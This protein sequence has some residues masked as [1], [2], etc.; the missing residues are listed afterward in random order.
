MAAGSV[1]SLAFVVKEV[2]MTL[3]P[4]TA[5]MGHGVPALPVPM[6]QLGTGIVL[7]ELLVLAVL[8]TLA[9]RRS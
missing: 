6:M 2:P 8:T 9:T 3:T 1:A 4:L 5:L 7:L